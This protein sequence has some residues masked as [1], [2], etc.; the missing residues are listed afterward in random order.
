MTCGDFYMNVKTKTVEIV[1]N[2]GDMGMSAE[3]LKDDFVYALIKTNDN[4][5]MLA[6]QVR[7]E[8]MERA[9]N[10]WDLSEISDGQLMNFK[11][12]LE[13]IL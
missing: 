5:D 7:K 9:R 6:E 1:G 8:L 11:D 12:V 4:F 2:E 3:I 13:M 10:A